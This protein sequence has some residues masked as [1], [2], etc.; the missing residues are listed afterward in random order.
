MVRNILDLYSLMFTSSG[1]NEK[2][3]ALEI[4]GP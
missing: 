1:E 3:E 2:H 4:F